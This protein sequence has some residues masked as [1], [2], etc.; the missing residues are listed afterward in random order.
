MKDLSMLFSAILIPAT[1][2]SNHEAQKNKDHYKMISI[3]P[4]LSKY[5]EN[6]SLS[7]YFTHS[8]CSFRDQSQNEV[9]VFV[10]I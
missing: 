3:S 9:H 10:S 5:V 8:L 7:T 1:K 6:V 4:E 2:L